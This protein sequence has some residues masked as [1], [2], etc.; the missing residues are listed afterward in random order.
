VLGGVPVLT[1]TFY[2]TTSTTPAK[3]L[4]GYVRTYVRSHV[5]SY[6]GT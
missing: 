6:Y 1:I 5:L 2:G 4:L 3:I